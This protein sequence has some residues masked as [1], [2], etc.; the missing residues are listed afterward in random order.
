MFAG[1]YLLIELR[2]ALAV[3]SEMTHLDSKAIIHELLCAQ[4][5]VIHEHSGIVRLVRKRFILSMRICAAIDFIIGRLH[6]A[7]VF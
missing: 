4:S 5:L 1:H 7:G 3:S 2:H 6:C